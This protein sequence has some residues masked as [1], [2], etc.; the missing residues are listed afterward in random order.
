MRDFEVRI[1]FK[2]IY[3]TANQAREKRYFWG[4][5]NLLS[6]IVTKILWYRNMSDFINSGYDLQIR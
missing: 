2:K 5:E 3:L 1:I 4:F 6:V